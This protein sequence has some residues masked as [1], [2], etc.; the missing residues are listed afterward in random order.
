MKN[1][2]CCPWKKQS[3]LRHLRGSSLSTRILLGGRRPV[4]EPSELSASW[5]GTEVSRSGLRSFLDGRVSPL[6]SSLRSA[7]F[8][9]TLPQRFLAKCLACRHCSFQHMQARR[10]MGNRAITGQN[11]RQGACANNSEFLEPCCQRH[12]LGGKSAFPTRV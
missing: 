12:Q 8:F 1:Q 7:A 6:V 5:Y 9:V 11:E 3:S 2:C 4:V 10:N